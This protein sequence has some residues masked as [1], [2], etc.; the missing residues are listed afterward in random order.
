[1]ASSQEP[2][3]PRI[4][5]AA[6]QMSLDAGPALVR[7]SDEDAALADGWQSPGRPGDRGSSEVCLVPSSQNEIPNRV[8]SH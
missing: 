4:L 5:P 8:L 3:R 6:K 7:P 2:A 1:M